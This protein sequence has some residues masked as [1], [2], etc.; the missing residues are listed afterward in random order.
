VCWYLIIDDLISLIKE[1]INPKLENCNHSIF[2]G[3][4]EWLNSIVWFVSRIVSCIS[5]ELLALYL[6]YKHKRENNET[7]HYFVDAKHVRLYG[8][9]A[10]DFGSIE[11]S[12]YKKK[13]TDISDGEINDSICTERMD[14]DGTQI[15]NYNNQM[16]ND[17]IMQ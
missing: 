13:M 16:E 12:F 11:S 7:T 4:A 5:S 2:S 3:S 17:P 15:I 9:D 14:G 6:F 10:E 1:L 8:S